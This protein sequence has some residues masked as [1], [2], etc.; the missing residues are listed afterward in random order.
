MIELLIACY[1]LAAGTISQH[2]VLWCI[3]D[4]TSW[5]KKALL[6]ALSP[7]LFACAVVGVL[8]IEFVKIVI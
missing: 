7:I 1:I 6:V 2:A 8:C 3:F 4:N 5:I